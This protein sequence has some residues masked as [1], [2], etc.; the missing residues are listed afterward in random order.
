[1]AGHRRWRRPARPYEGLEEGGFYPRG[2]VLHPQALASNNPSQNREKGEDS[3]RGQSSIALRR[4]RMEKLPFSIFDQ[5]V[6]CIRVVFVPV[7]IFLF[8]LM[9]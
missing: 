7:H 2:Y 1:M 4:E 6:V 9:E 8:S 5:T 3:M